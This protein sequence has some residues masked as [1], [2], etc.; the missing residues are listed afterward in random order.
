MEF[1]LIMKSLLST[2]YLFSNSKRSS[3]LKKYI[4]FLH[5]KEETKVWVI[6]RQYC[7]YSYK[8]VKFNSQIPLVSVN[9]MLQ[10]TWKK[11]RKIILYKPGFSLMFQNRNTWM[12]FYYSKNC[13]WCII[14]VKYTL[15]KHNIKTESTATY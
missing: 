11:F 9:N 1:V 12:Y 7:T 10:C 13:V 3:S 8:V 5:T 4:C 2:E 6:L 14:C 15:C